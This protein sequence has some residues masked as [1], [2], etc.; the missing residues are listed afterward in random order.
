MAPVTI[1][2][3]EAAAHYRYEK[4]NRR[5]GHKPNAYLTA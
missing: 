2:E 5:K 1:G 4:S 3:E